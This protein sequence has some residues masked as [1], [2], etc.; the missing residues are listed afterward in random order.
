MPALLGEK[1]GEIDRVALQLLEKDEQPVVGHPL[2]IKDAVEMVAFV[3]DDPGVE[4][5]DLALDHFAVEPRS[6]IA[7]PQMARHDPAQPGNREAALPAERPLAPDRLDHRV[8]QHRQILRDIAGHVAEALLR[9]LKD[10]DPVGLM[11]LRRGD[12]GAAGILHRLDHVLDEPAHPGRGR[13]VDRAGDAAQYRVPHAGDL[14]Q[15]HGC[16]MCRQR[17]GVKRPTGWRFTA[18]F[19][20]AKYCRIRAAA[21]RRTGCALRRKAPVQVLVR[22]NNV[23]QALRALKK[24]MQ[25]EGVFREMKLR[26]NYEK[27]SE[28]RARKR[29]KRCAAT[30]SCCANAW[31]AKATEPAPKGQ[32]QPV[33][34]TPAKAGVQG[35]RRPGAA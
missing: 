25:R 26:R 19:K 4:A 17:S 5:L 28:R 22:D 10:D 2:R 32:H 14:E 6:A 1:G 31:S 9:H 23:D 30:A 29:P 33:L 12:A 13:V 15:S 35:H 18:A 24:K 21:A 3:L 20:S 27:P 8:D 16:N 34:V 7:D 11:D